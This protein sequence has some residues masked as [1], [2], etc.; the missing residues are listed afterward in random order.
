VDD[1]I[2]APAGRVLRDL[3]EGPLRRVVACLRLVPFNPAAGIA[4]D[5]DARGMSLEQRQP[6]PSDPGEAG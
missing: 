5:D 1:Q 4:D 2:G 6:L 3:G